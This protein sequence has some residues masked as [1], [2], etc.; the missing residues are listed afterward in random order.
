MLINILI[1]ITSYQQNI[2]KQNNS[3]HKRAWRG[4]TLFAFPASCKRT[5]QEWTTATNSDR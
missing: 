3:T 5:F 2:T 1:L 4:D